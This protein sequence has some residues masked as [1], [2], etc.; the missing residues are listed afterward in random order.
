ML[1]SGKNKRHGVSNIMGMFL[2][3]EVDG[4]GASH[5][6]GRQGSTRATIEVSSFT[7]FFSWEVSR[8]GNLRHVPPTKAGVSPEKNKTAKSTTG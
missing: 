4:E 7:T 3:R 8:F 6:F 1:Q 2:S 5:F